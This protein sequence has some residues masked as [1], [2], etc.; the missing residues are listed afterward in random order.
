MTSPIHRIR[1]ECPACG[2][3]FVDWWRPSMNFGLESFTDEY[4][5]QASTATCPQCG[6]VTEVGALLVLPTDPPVD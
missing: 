4:V 3:S 6:Y 5:R 1:V 2:H